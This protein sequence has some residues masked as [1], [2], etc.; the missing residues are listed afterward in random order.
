[1]ALN[2]G[3]DRR[4]KLEWLD[5]AAWKA[6]TETDITEVRKYLDDFLQSE[7]QSRE[8]R[9]KTI[10][11]LT[12][13][14]VRVPQKHRSLQERAL[15]ILTEDGPDTR[16][17]LH[18]GMTLVAYPFFRDIADITGRLLTLQ[19][20]VSLEQVYRRLA[21]RWGERSTVRRASQRVVRSMVDWGVLQDT[22]VKGVY[23][24]AAKKGPA[25][26][27]VQLWFLEALL[28]SESTQAVI[29]QQLPK[30]PSAFPFHL[31]ISVANIRQS[32]RFEI[33]RQGL[34]LDMVTI[35]NR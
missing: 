19:N 21:E 35:V 15:E 7:C 12:R 6:A 9:R 5:A 3:F 23:I 24:P 2:I 17:W 27:S 22:A 13:I 18:W 16:L 10:T 31:D 20:E 32:K 26:A 1:M 34:D 33:Q 8:A 28:Y 30:L 29:L 14:W 4:V 25:S 11:V